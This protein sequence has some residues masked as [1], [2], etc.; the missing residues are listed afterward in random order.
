MKLPASAIRREG[1]GL[2]KNPLHPA[3][4]RRIPRRSPCAPL[5]PEPVSRSLP[6][7]DEIVRRVLDGSTDAFRILV[8]RHERPVFSLAYRMVGNREEAED[9]AQESFVRAFRALDRFDPAHRFSS[10][11]LRITNN[12]SID[13]LRSRRVAT[14]SLDGPAD[15]DAWDG[16]GSGRLD[17]PD[18]GEDPARSTENRALGRAI[19]GAIGR[20]RP[21]YRAVVVLR[22]VEGY[23]Y[24]EIATV[25]DLPLGTVKTHLHR[26]RIELRDHLREFAP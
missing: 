23:T 18:S 25:L 9:I 10:W 22:H 26:A 11:I 6:E 8:E 16:A 12:L 7:D 4:P 1:P 14:V 24:D 21:E 3:P 13:H 2:E 15:P 17:P 19:E 5:R 20:L